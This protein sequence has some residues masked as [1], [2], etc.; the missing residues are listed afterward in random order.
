MKTDSVGLALWTETYGGS[1]DDRAYS[2]IEHSID[3]GFVLAGRTT[4]FGAGGYDVMLVKT[5]S[6]GVEMW[7]KTY[8]GPGNEFADSVIEH[9]IDQGLLLAGATTGYGAG[10]FDLILVKTNSA[11]VEVWTKTYGGTGVDFYYSLI[12]HSIDTGFLLG[13]QTTSIGAGSYDMMLVKTN[14]VALGCGQRLM[15]E[16][17]LTLYI[18]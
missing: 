2:L 9:T 18:L 5:N 6:V 7:T 16:P 15:E 14:S 11:G 13:G 1:G 17:V 10:S 12:E 3:T 4:T 8:G